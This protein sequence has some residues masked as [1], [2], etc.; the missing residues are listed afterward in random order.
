[1]AG[2]LEAADFYLSKVLTLAKDAND[3]DKQAHRDFVARAKAMINNLVPY[4]NSHFKM[5]LSWN[6]KV[7]PLFFHPLSLFLSLSP[8]LSLCA[9]SR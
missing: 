5:G 9:R 4:I 8:S 2:T 3:A 6:V 7:I 1:M